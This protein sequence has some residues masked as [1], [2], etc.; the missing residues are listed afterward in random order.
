VL[1]EKPGYQPLTAT[2]AS[3]GANVDRFL[4]PAD[5]DYRLLPERI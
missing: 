2:P 5:D 1:V 4:R 3:L